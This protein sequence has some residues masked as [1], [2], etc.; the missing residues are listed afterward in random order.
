VGKEEQLQ[1]ERKWAPAAAISA[2]AA[3]LVPF[4]GG[5]WGQAQLG[6]IDA[7]REDLLLLR[8]HENAGVYVAAGILAAIGMVF[9]APVFVYLFHAIKARRPQIPQIA[10]I[11]AIAA[12]LVAAGTS[13]AGTVVIVPVANEFV[14]EPLKPATASQ[15]QKLESATTAK[16]RQKVLDDIGPPGQA[17]DKLKSGS[18]TTVRYISLVGTLMLAIAFVL[19][20]MNAMRAGLL[21]RFMGILGV[22]VGALA[23]LPLFGAPGQIIQLF[24][25]AAMGVLFLDRW[26]QGRG[27]AWEEVEA[28]P[29]PTAQERRDASMDARE[30]GGRAKAAAGEPEPDVHH[31]REAA[32]PRPSTA[33]PR[34][35]KRKRKRRG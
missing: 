20:S 27:S 26:P 28:I 23:V 9:L 30:G 15:K 21:S 19:I 12:P 3:G 33:H 31:T 25:V 11:L 24:W 1:W 8:I 16:D 4:A 14:K 17:R 22:I 6:R 32:R 13:I 5:I 7:N 35:K 29:W 10:L 18:L 2:F 34:S